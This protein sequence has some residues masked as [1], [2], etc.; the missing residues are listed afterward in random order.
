[1]YFLFSNTT[2]FLSFIQRHY[3]YIRLST[4]RLGLLRQPTVTFLS[5]TEFNTLAAGEGDERFTS[6]AC[7]NDKQVS[8]PGSKLNK[9]RNRMLKRV[10]KKAVGT[11]IPL[12]ACVT[13]GAHID[14][15]QRTLLSARIF[16]RKH[17]GRTHIGATEGMLGKFV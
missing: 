15:V 9:R 5:N 4:R 17:H 2:L 12:C 7:T 11:M 1:M 14:P 10:K 6:F 16:L 8:E 3:Y 13:N